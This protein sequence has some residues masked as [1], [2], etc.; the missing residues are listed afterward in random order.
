[1]KKLDRRLRALET[2]LITDPIVLYLPGGTTR[3]IFGRGEYLLDLFDRVC[4]RAAFSPQE[5]ADLEAI[6]ESVGAQEGGGHMVEVV[7]CG[8]LAA[9]EERE[10]DG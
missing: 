3:Q 4:R 5:L 10:T 1:M 7:K 9:A 8:L 2:K 6:R